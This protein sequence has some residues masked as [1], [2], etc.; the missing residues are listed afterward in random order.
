LPFVIGMMGQNGSKEAKGAMKVIQ[1]AQMAME[2]LPKV[3]AVRTDVLI[4]KAAEALY[5]TWR[6]NISEWEKVGSDHGY[7]YL[8]SAIWLN[9]I[10]KS[11]AEA[12][13]ELE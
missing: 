4:D 7:H 2:K 1:D 10:G 9:R 8:G 13:L 3:K 5:P 6:E 12:L 11:F